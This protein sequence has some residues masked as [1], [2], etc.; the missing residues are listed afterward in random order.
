MVKFSSAFLSAGIPVT[1]AMRI[2]VQVLVV[3]FCHQWCGLGHHGDG[4]DGR[5][6]LEEPGKMT[7]KAPE[8]LKS[9]TRQQDHRVMENRQLIDIIH[10]YIY[11]WYSQLDSLIEHADCL[12][13]SKLATNGSIWMDGGA[14][15]KRS[16]SLSKRK[17]TTREFLGNAS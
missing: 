14:M 9:K 10:I 6:S 5:F 8:K 16:G 12:W 3:S 15:F 7:G 17:S 1:M 2:A 11:E 4:R 13:Q